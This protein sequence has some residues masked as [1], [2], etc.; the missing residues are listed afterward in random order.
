MNYIGIM[1][2]MYTVPIDIDKFRVYCIFL[3]GSCNYNG[4]T[5]VRYNNVLYANVIRP[6]GDWHIGQVKWKIAKLYINE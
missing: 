4:S 5:S 6:Q 2:S 1:W 3:K